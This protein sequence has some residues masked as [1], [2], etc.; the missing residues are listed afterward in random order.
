MDRPTFIRAL[1][2]SGLLADERVRAPVHAAAAQ[3]LD[4]RGL[5]RVL[6][7][8]NLLTPYQA[9]QLLT[10]KGREL[11]LGPYLLLERLGHGGMGQVYKAVHRTHGRVVAVKVL[12]R[13][14]LQNPRAL[15]RFRREIEAAG[16]LTHPNIVT[17]L[18]AAEDNGVLFLV[19]EYVEGTNLNRL[20]KQSG[21][22]P[23]DLACHCIRQAALGLQHVHERGL[24]HRD[25]KP[26]N[27]LIQ[28]TRPA[29]NG[30]PAVFGA[31]KLLDL[32]LARI[33]EGS[34]V[35]STGPALTQLNQ[36]MGTPD[37]MAPEQARDAKNADHR[38][39]LYSLGAT[40]Y[41]CLA[42]RPPFPEGTPLEK[43]IKHQFDE[44]TP[45]ERVRPP[46]PPALAQIVRWMMAKDPARR[47]QSAAE[48]AAA[49]ARLQ[50]PA[51]AAPAIGL[52]AAGHADADSSQSTLHF[53]AADAP[54]A[55]ICGRPGAGPSHREFWLWLVLGLGFAGVLL[56]AWLVL[57]TL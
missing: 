12:S 46:T 31:V 50:V 20:V 39:D 27:L 55:P 53:A 52:P 9:N 33:Q 32:G 19:M 57:R 44:P 34:A 2:Q 54:L 15:A 4:G 28:M 47:P 42:G 45:L 35:P 51:G 36:I 30:G 43:L 3:A 24:V 5:A 16:K 26:S 38:S 22:L 14:L 21:P 40:F 17:A 29:G 25:L 56:A 18:D 41:Y 13:H 48:V 1:E 10:G 23:F 8:Q 11:T 37:Y 6:V 49:L 7:R